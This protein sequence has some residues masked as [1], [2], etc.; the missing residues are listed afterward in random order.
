MR[1]LFITKDSPYSLGGA[2]FATHAYLRALSDVCH[3]DIDVFMADSIREDDSIKVHAFFR[4]PERSFFNK[5]L[6]LFTGELSRYAGP[7]ID[8]LK[9]D[10]N[11]DVCIFN[12]CKVTP[13]IIDYVKRQGI[14]IVTIHHN[15]EVEYVRDNTPNPFLRRLLIR[16]VSKAEKHSYHMSD[17]NLFLTES[18]KD[19]FE[20]MYWGNNS[21]NTVIGTYEFK[22]LPL[23]KEKVFSEERLCVAIT[24]SLCTVQ[25]I[26]GVKYFFSE[27]ID[28]IPKS[29]RIIISGRTP[30][31]EVVWLCNKHDNV[32]LIPN[33]I[34]MNEVINE[35]DIYI[36]PTRLGGGLKLRIMD[37]L[38]LGIPVLSH[39]CSARGYDAFEKSGFFYSFNN[40][41]ELYSAIEELISNLRKGRI[42]RAVIQN[43]YANQFSYSAGLERMRTA[44]NLII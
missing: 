31:Q 23:I 7:V 9:N 11:Y 43:K 37:A 44:I 35:A 6:S 4:V 30:S 34:D 36:C 1:F 13:S 20:K 16:K 5:V 28:A 2:G 33:P 22:E 14:K 38:R 17:L 25:G 42:S 18:D 29:T 32:T 12:N 40:G 10:S 39:A 15:V 21:F 24:G 27:L 3:G 41:Q 19:A 26:D 8:H